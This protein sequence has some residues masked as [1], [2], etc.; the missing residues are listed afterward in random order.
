VLALNTWQHT[1]RS[2]ATAAAPAVLPIAIAPSGY[3]NSSRTLRGL[4]N[5]EPTS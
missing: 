4:T 5:Q 1:L 3:I 2:A